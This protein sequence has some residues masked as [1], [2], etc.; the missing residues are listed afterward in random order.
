[1]PLQ[2]VYKR[3]LV[4]FSGH[5]MNCETISGVA[6]SMLS[7]RFVNGAVRCFTDINSMSVSLVN[8]VDERDQIDLIRT[9]GLGASTKSN[10]LQCLQ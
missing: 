7:A 10:N 8:E 4:S 6:L 3:N 5:D 1:M 2:V 9:Q